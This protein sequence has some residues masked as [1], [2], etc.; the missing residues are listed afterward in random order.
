MKAK[1]GNNFKITFELKLMMIFFFFLVGPK[2]RKA[3]EFIW[4]NVTKLEYKSEWPLCRDPKNGV[5]C[6]CN[7]PL[8]DFKLKFYYIS[9]RFKDY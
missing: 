9:H 3:S 7:I 5:P 4:A 6:Y 1:Q 8:R 2:W